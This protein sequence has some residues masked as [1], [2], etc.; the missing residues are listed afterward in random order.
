MLWACLSLSSRGLFVEVFRLSISS[1]I[2]MLPSVT[3]D[4]LARRI[5][6]NCLLPVMGTPD[7]V[8]NLSVCVFM[9]LFTLPLTG[10]LLPFIFITVY[11]ILPQQSICYA[12][13]YEIY[14][15][16]TKTYTPAS[17]HGPRRVRGLPAS[18]RRARR[19]RGVRRAGAVNSYRVGRSAG[20]PVR[21]AAPP[22]R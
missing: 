13:F 15:C 8:A 4:C 14:G 12:Q 11:R 18:G 7:P 2:D 16:N 10:Q 17:I 5:C 6:A 9:V 19:R 21:G 1:S 22:T 3:R 20:F